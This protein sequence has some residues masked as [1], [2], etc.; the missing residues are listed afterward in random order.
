MAVWAAIMSA[1][2]PSLRV[3][4]NCVLLVFDGKA[5]DFEDSYL[6]CSIF[7]AGFCLCDEIRGSGK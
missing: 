7:E 6:D 4:T 5:K 3:N 2:F 1:E